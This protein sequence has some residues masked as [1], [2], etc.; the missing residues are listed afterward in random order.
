MKSHRFGKTQVWVNDYVEIQTCHIYTTDSNFG[1]G[2]I[3]V[4]ENKSFLLTRAALIWTKIQKKGEILL[5]F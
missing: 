5:Q 4:L 3:Y 1:V 2:K